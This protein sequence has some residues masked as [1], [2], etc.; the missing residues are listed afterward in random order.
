MK[1]IYKRELKS[2]FQ[3]MIGYAY[4]AF[5]M[6]FT[7]I[8]FTFYN[9]LSGVPFFSYTLSA[10]MIIFLIAVPVL[11]MKSFAEERKSRTDQMLLT[12]PVSVTKIV[13][14][15][16][17]AMITVYAI[18]VLLDCLYPL[19][20]NAQGTAYLKVDYAAILVYFAIGSVYIAVGMF[21]SSLTESQIIA[22]ISTFV[23][24]LIMNMWSGLISFLPSAANYN[25]I[26]LLLIVLVIAYLLYLIT[27]NWMIGGGVAVAGVA[28]SA[29]TY[30]INKDWY[31]NLL[32]DVLSKL[33]FSSM[34]ANVV[35][36]SL[37]NVT[38]LV[39]CFSIILVFV[40]L[41][42]QMIQKRRWS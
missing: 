40:F 11:T 20:I 19:I 2:Y 32:S 27:K 5:M 17:L 42:V 26:G 22:A 34:L 36:T 25:L 41:T 14:G 29:I 3:S 31:A 39:L 8:Y 38:D 18:P 4:I 15:K 21:L 23:V 12:A 33:D 24:L 1:A 7:G 10:T 16:Y 13:L 37:L 6:L 9:L 30:M 28:A 35:N